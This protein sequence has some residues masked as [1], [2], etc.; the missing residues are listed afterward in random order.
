LAQKHLDELYLSGKLIYL[1]EDK[2]NVH[3][4]K[5]KDLSIISGLPEEL[6]HYEEIYKDQQIIKIRLERRKRRKDVTIIEGIDDKS[7][8]IEKIATELKTKFACGGTTKN[9]RIELQ[10]DHRIKVKKALIEMGF[11]A[12][13][14]IVE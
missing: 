8:D 6:L 1:V 9:S 2:I 12:E 11:P 10:G 5:E 4:M 3:K 14:I 13:N 7:I